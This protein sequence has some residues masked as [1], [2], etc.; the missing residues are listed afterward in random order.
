MVI[1][2]VPAISAAVARRSYNETGEIAESSMRISAVIALPMGVGLSVLAYPIVHVLYK[3][4]HEI[5]PS[6]LALL[7]IASFFV[8]M[9]LVTNAILQAHGNEKLPV[10]SMIVG[11]VVKIA[12]NL[13]LVGNP[14]VNILGAPIGTICCYVVICVM[15]CIFISRSLECRPDYGK[16]FLRP[17]LSSVVMGGAAWAAYGLL[18]KVLSGAGDLSRLMMAAAM[19]AAIAVGVEVYL[20]LVICTRSITADDMKLIPRGDKLAKLLKI[21]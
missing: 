16:V 19:L 1:S 17:L 4:T 15:N 6:I 8:C 11:G 12:A 10:L 21:R 9:S 3:D 13:L 7:G 20:I 2:V 18:S 14:A 5:G